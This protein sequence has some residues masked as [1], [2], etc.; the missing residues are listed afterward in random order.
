MFLYVN[1]KNVRHEGVNR[2][3]KHNSKQKENIDESLIS[4]E[5]LRN[6]QVKGSGAV[7][8]IDVSHT[9]HALIFPIN[10]IYVSESTW[11]FKH[12]NYSFPATSQWVKFLYKLEFK[13]VFPR[14]SIDLLFFSISKSVDL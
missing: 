9:H 6:F 11:S 3:T 1:G 5:A 12:K 4:Y 8:R 14:T 10:R 7:Q 13:K 2:T